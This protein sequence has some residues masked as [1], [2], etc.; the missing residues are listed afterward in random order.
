MQLSKQGR[1]RSQIADLYR[2][3][4]DA[5][6]DLPRVADGETAYRRANAGFAHTFQFV[7]VEDYDGRGE[8]TPSAHFYQ[9]LGEAEPVCAFAAR[10]QAGE[11]A[12][13]SVLQRQQ[14]ELPR[15]NSARVV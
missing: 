3:R 7:N 14:S 15:R 13:R 5:L 10:R 1:A 2:W 4:Y 11:K 12:R 8:S 9:N 6:G